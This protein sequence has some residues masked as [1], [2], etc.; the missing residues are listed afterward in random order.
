MRL[1]C[2]AAVAMFATSWAARAA[3]LQTSNAD[4]QHGKN[5]S[6]SYSKSR[7]VIPEPS[8]VALLGTGLLGF[9]GV[10]RRRS[11]D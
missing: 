8:G 11:A 2:V 4:A 9:A 1:L 10:I 3:G 6:P 7:I 5:T